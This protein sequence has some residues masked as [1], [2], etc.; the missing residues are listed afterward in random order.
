MVDMMKKESDRFYSFV[1]YSGFILRFKG[2]FSACI[3]QVYFF[4]G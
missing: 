1:L 3:A 4:L 2:V